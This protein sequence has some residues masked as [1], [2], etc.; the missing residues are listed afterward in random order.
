M[1]PPAAAGDTGRDRQAMNDTTLPADGTA[2]SVGPA[3]NAAANQV[4][5]QVAS[6]VGGN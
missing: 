4:A 1:R 5:A 3:L 6:W 2:A